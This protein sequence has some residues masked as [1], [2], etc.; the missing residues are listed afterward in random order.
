[1]ND[2]T[3]STHSVVQTWFSGSHKIQESVVGYLDW[4]K[5]HGMGKAFLS[6]RLCGRTQY[7]LSGTRGF[8]QPL[9]WVADYWRRGFTHLRNTNWTWTWDLRPNSLFNQVTLYVLQAEGITFFFTEGVFSHTL[10]RWGRRSGYSLTASFCWG[11]TVFASSPRVWTSN[12]TILFISTRQESWVLF[13]PRRC[14]RTDWTRVFESS[15]TG[16]GVRLFQRWGKVWR[17]RKVTLETRDSYRKWPSYLS[18]CSRS[19]WIQESPKVG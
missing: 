3:R 9:E 10:M 5:K 1:M 4:S 12:C 19:W 16:G 8:S 14:Q 2:T 18:F 11:D 6:L 7:A 15:E 17:L 13:A